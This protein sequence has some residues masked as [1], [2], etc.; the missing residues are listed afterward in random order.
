VD[1]YGPHRYFEVSHWGEGRSILK[2]DRAIYELRQHC[3]AASHPCH[4]VTEGQMPPKIRLQGGALE[5]IIDSKDKRNVAREALLWQNPFFGSKTRHHVRIGGWTKSSN[6]PLAM[7]AEIIDD[8]QQ[9][10]YLPKSL[11]AWCRAEVQGER[12]KVKAASLTDRRAK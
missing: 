5:R 8:V 7:R 11:I 3:T 1:D 9:Y 10:V 6:S 12:E 4:K 2:L